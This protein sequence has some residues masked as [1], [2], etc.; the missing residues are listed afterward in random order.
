MH[1]LIRIKSELDGKNKTSSSYKQFKTSHEPCKIATCGCMQLEVQLFVAADGC[2]W[3][4]AGGM[5]AADGWA[6]GC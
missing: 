2:Y 1:V 4:V 6:G 5:V 3:L